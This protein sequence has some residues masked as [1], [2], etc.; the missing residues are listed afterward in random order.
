MV[1]APSDQ[2]GNGIFIIVTLTM[3]IYIDPYK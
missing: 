1:F 2:S 3:T